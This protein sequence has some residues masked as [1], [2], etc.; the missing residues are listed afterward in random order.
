MPRTPRALSPK[1]LNPFIMKN[2]DDDRWALGVLN[3]CNMM[4]EMYASSLIH[5]YLPGDCILAKLNLLKRGKK[6]R[7]N[8][9]SPAGHV[10]L[11]R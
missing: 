7:I 11:R 8:R 5:P 10:I 6:V 9:R 3:A 2:T 1:D 4:N